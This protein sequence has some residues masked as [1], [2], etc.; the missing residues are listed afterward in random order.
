MR[1]I[2]TRWSLVL[3]MAAALPAL[4]ASPAYGP[5]I[6][7]T[8]IKIG[9]TMPYSGPVSAYGTQGRVHAAYYRMINE[10][11]GVNGRKIKL[12]SLD[13][14]YTPPKTV[15]Q[16]R[17][18]VEQEEVFAI[19]GAL[20]TAQVMSVRK[21][22]NEHRVP[23]VFAMTGTSAFGDY[24]HF[25][26]S[27][28]W[29]PTFHAEGRVFAKFILQTAPNAKIAILYPNDDLGKDYLGGVR[30][31]LG[32]KAKTMIVGEQSYETTDP[33][34][35]SQVVSLQATGA[36]VF[37][38][39]ATPK[40]AA[41]AIRKVYAVG[42][43]PMHLLSYI[44][45]SYSAVMEPAGVEKGIGII[46]TVFF[47]DPTN[48]VFADDAEVR[49]WS[50]FMDKYYPEGSKSDVFNVV[51]YMVAE[52][53][54]ELL[55]KCGDDLTRENLMKQAAHLDLRVPMLLPGIHI[56]TSPTDFYPIKEVRLEKFDGKAF[57]LFG[58]TMSA[59]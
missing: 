51:G 45:A 37:I 44:S 15:E 9:Q 24:E 16:T 12:I 42:W 32:D 58:E 57:V 54:V 33:T 18:L 20:G 17:K 59:E 31:A 39:I 26:W 8:E 34:V 25:P 41:Q 55:K 13:D 11:G 47:K 5:G 50:A 19:A 48:P 46:S 14:G 21:Y 1:P 43:K 27:M 40:F 52:T 7:D 22:L 28:A 36:D 38:D 10:Q 29:Q 49:A 4:A 2:A 35:D 3:A 30:D 53:F 56:G 6:S 23:Q